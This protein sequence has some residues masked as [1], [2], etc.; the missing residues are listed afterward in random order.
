MT[1]EY[2]ANKAVQREGILPMVKTAKHL[3]SF[4]YHSQTE[5]EQNKFFLFN[6]NYVA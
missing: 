2:W 6:T 5:S 4:I 1:D 3:P